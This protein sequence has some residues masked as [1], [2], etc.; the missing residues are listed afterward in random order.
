[1][2]KNYFA[3]IPR[4]NILPEIVG[5]LLRETVFH[6]HQ[7]RAVNF[8]LES[9]LKRDRV[10]AIVRQDAQIGD[11]EEPFALTT[12]NHG[13]QHFGIRLACEIRPGSIYGD[14]LP[15]PDGRE[16]SH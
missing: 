4:P 1:M 14:R 6:C 12:Q 10:H 11:F 5:V 3:L 9:R 2:I 15:F 16:S 13:L 7:Q 8:I